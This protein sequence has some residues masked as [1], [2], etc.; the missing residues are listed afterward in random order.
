MEHVSFAEAFAASLR[1]RGLGLDRLRHHLAVAGFSV[2]NAT[3]SYWMSGRSRPTRARSL[4]VV[5]EIERILGTP[6]GYLRDLIADPHLAFDWTKVTD[7][8]IDIDAAFA[9]LGV[10]ELG[11]VMVGTQER[12]KVDAHRR[13]QRH[14]FTAIRQAMTDGV[15]SF[16][17]VHKIDGS[18]TDIRMVDTSHVRLGRHK[19]FLPE[20]L[21]VAEML[22]PRPLAKGEL[23]QTSYAIEWDGETPQSS[24]WETGSEGRVQVQAIHVEFHPDAVPL[25]VEAFARPEGRVYAESQVERSLGEVQLCG[26]YANFVNLEPL[27]GV[28]GLEWTWPGGPS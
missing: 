28:V 22:L 15:A 5:A 20:G 24:R 21:L 26:R 16:L 2:S 27:S 12:V 1:A 6:S 4:Q 8:G 25:R 11:L 19:A 18:P 14:H 7:S 10:D 3:L 9:E 13:E 23:V 17:G